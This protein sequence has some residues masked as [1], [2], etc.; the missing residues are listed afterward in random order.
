MSEHSLLITLT[1]TVS[2]LDRSEFI[3]LSVAV[4]EK[5]YEAYK[6]ILEGV[7][8]LP[9]I[10]GHDQFVVLFHKDEGSL[11]RRISLGQGTIDLD[12]EGQKGNYF[13]ICKTLAELKVEQIDM[14]RVLMQNIESGVLNGESKDPHMHWSPHMKFIRT[15]TPDP[16]PTPL[17]PISNPNPSPSSSMDSIIQKIGKQSSESLQVLLAA[18]QLEANKRGLIL[19]NPSG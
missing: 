3:D 19:P 8:K 16:K 4:L 18:L 10:H 9:Q 6:D 15:S 5:L 2:S 12:F 14:Y 13:S 17:K 7:L 11:C 1:P